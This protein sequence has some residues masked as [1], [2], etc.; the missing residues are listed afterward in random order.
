MD[1]FKVIL[2]AGYT[3]NA[4]DF[5]ELLGALN[6]SRR[7]TSVQQLEQITAFFIRACQLFGFDQEQV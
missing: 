4:E 7:I 5:V 1:A 6:L 2:Q 3:L